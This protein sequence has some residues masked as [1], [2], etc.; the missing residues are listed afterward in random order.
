MG[1]GHRACAG[2]AIS[3]FGRLA[4]GESEAGCEDDVVLVI[5]GNRLTYILIEEVHVGRHPAIEL[6]SDSGSE[7]HAIVAGMTVAR[8]RNVS[9]LI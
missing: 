4:E 9:G 1:A 7:V 5:A 2:F 6:C 8:K 3:Q